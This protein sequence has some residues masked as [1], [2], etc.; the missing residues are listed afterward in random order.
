MYC[1]KCLNYS[2]QINDKGIANIIINGKRMDRGLIY[3]KFTDEFE[4]R[5]SKEKIKEKIVEFFAWYSKFQNILP[6]TR[7]E[8][9]TSDFNCS[10]KCVIP[11]NLQLSI[12]D[13]IISKN[14]LQLFL[15]D[16][17]PKYGLKIEL[18]I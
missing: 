1:P 15:D 9:T 14:E 13:I 5:E 6:I 3:F 10:K 17:A 18:V 7:V 4:Q 12:I 8:L 11:P 16:I 2:L